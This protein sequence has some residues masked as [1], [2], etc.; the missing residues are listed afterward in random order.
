MREPNA[1]DPGAGTRE[2][3]ERHVVRGDCRDVEVA[4]RS[5][6]MSFV[7]AALMTGYCIVWRSVLDLEFAVLNAAAYGVLFAVA[8]GAFQA[9]RRFA[10]R[11]P[12]PSCFGESRALLLAVGGYFLM[13]GPAEVAGLG[14][15]A[16]G[17]S[18]LAGAAVDAFWLVEVG[19]RRGV[20]LRRAAVLALSAPPFRF[21]R[22]RWTEGGV[23]R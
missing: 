13:A 16:T 17:I 9:L 23:R 15:S 10:A 6:A 4:W 20:G 18:L 22:L 3:D 1:G 14:L 7:A 12:R 11:E 21:D 19:A 2:A 5:L 8:W